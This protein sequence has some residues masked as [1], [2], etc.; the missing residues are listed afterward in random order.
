MHRSTLNNFYISPNYRYIF[1]VGGDAF[2]KV[3]DYEFSLKGPGS[4]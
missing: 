4:S 1:S 2:L 3:W